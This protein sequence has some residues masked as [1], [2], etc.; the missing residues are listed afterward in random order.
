MARIFT[1]EA[2]VQ[3]G[4][5]ALRFPDP[6]VSREMTIKNELY[7]FPLFLLSRPA[8]TQM[9]ALLELVFALFFAFSRIHKNDIALSPQL[10]L[11]SSPVISRAESATLFVATPHPL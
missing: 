4:E 5:E 3:L 2:C 8:D 6:G 10:R 1:R 9:P 7:C 11:S